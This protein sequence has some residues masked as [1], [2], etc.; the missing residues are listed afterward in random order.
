MYEV[1]LKESAEDLVSQHA[2]PVGEAQR[3]YT[4]CQQAQRLELGD[5][6]GVGINRRFAASI[7]EGE[8][9]DAVVQPEAH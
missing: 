3:V 9:A 8:Q 6:F 4:G 5:R 7:C 1:G 2:P